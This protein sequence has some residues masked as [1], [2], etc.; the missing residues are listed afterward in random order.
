MIDPQ[1]LKEYVI[2]PAL[3]YIDMYNVGAAQLL[4]GT[5][6]VESQMGYYLHQIN[7]PA[8]GIYQMEPDTENDIW[9]N[10]INFRPTLKSKVERYY[11]RH[12]KEDNLIS[13]LGYATI[14]ARLKY[15]RSKYKI[16]E[17]N[18][19]D[20]MAKMWRFVYNTRLGAHDDK[21]AIEKYKDGYKQY[22]SKIYN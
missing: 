20:A 1:Q 10:Y 8:L 6:A 18:D 7:G 2:R 22:V 17:P 15:Y 12:L 14:M 19:L 16:P 4:L 11:I 13:N 5:A 3:S 21:T 9:V